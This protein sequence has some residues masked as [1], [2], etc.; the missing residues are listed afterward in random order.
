MN[1]HSI[2]TLYALPTCKQLEEG[3]EAPDRRLGAVSPRDDGLR[4]ARI[5]A[6]LLDLRCDIMACVETRRFTARHR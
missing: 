2:S 6:H 3:V 1:F 5:G 4:L